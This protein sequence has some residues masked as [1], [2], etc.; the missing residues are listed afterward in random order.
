[1]NIYSAELRVSYF[2]P[3]SEKTRQRFSIPADPFHA[4]FHQIS[5]KTFGHLSGGTDRDGRD[6]LSIYY[7]AEFRQAP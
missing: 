7:G 2:H 6:F 1:M 5:D 4:L 3:L